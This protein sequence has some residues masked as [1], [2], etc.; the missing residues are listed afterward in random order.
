M[1]ITKTD[2]TDIHA[3]S[4]ARIAVLAK[5]YFQEPFTIGDTVQELD[6]F[7]NVLKEGVLTSVSLASYGAVKC[8][9]K[10]EN[11]ATT[12]TYYPRGLRKKPDP[13]IEVFASDDVAC[14][15][16]KLWKATQV[17]GNHKYCGGCSGDLL[18][19]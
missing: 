10:L 9:F 12:F 18:E 15:W 13:V 7:G 14:D 6:M 1:T 8:F 2:M 17:H 16:C 5:H 11:G 19:D 3:E 4:I